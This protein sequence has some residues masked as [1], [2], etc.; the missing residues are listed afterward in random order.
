M[1]TSALTIFKSGLW[2]NNAALVQLLGLCPLLAVTNNLIKGLGLGI[3]TTFVLVAANLTVSLTRK[4]IP[5]QIRIP[6]F[7][8]LIA[9]FVTMIQLL[10]KAFAY[11][12]FLAL[13]IFIPLIVTNCAIIGRAE[14]FASHNKPLASMVDGL[15]HGLGFSLLLMLLGGLRELIGQGSLLSDAHILFGDSAQ[16]LK[17]S[18]Y[19][20]ELKF[21]LAILAPGAFV[22]LGLLVALKNA[23]VPASESVDSEN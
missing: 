16:N 18:F 12:L 4:Q 6:I 22:G 2:S 5:Q 13:G 9:S 17:L 7:V 21:L 23:L 8:L 1:Q 15:A 10:I 14:S 20:G 19:H 11:E 3:A